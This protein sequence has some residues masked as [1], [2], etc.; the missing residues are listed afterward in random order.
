MRHIEQ[1]ASSTRSSRAAAC[2]PV[3]IT[4][5][6]SGLGHA[7]ARAFRAAGIATIATARREEELADL[8]AL[9]CDTLRLDV[10]DEASRQAAVEAAQRRHGR[11]GVLI[12]NAGY[13]Q[14]GPLEEIPL[15][16]VRCA[17]ETNVFG[18]LR[19]AQLVLPGMRAAGRGRIVNVG[20]IAGRVT[21]QGGGVY[22]MTKHAVEALADA[23]RPEVEP[24]GIDVVN[25]LPGPF[26]SSYRDKIVASIPENGSDGPYALYKRSVAKYMLGF[27]KPGRSGV[28]S[29]EQVAQV[30][31]E[32]ATARRPRT[33]YAVGL[34]ARLGPLGRALAPDRLF[35]R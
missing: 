2:E 3:L 21:V 24:F 14:Y 31:L 15:D 23:L 13:G 20:S 22:H 30:V 6:S 34:Y 9:G 32:A 33:R 27:L 35:E 25:V 7:A 19:M 4:G 5:C 12:N 18:M 8:R 26:V 28:M 29:A 1:P 10:T 11:I 16:A 17:F